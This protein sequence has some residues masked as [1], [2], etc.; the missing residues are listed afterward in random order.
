MT[1]WTRLFT[2]MNNSCASTDGQSHNLFKLTKIGGIQPNFLNIAAHLP[3]YR[4]TA[5]L[6][7]YCSPSSWICWPI[8]FELTSVKLL[9]MK[10]NEM[11]KMKW[12]NSKPWTHPFSKRMC[13]KWLKRYIDNICVINTYVVYINPPNYCNLIC[14]QHIRFV[15]LCNWKYW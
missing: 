13:Q 11:K 14:W 1:T 12:W 4:T 9:E 3:E 15:R 2:S 7:K 6:P 10:W 8:R 5:Q